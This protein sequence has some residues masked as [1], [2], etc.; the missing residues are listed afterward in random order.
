VKK[1]FSVASAVHVM[2]HARGNS[3]L[4]LPDLDV[5]VALFLIYLLHLPS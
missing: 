1:L 2:Q 5:S 3:S 4:L